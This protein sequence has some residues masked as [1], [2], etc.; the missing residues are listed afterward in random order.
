[1]HF[2]PCNNPDLLDFFDF[3][4]HYYDKLRERFYLNF[5]FEEDVI[6]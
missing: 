1:M 3:C 2:Y 4:L 5:F 6:D